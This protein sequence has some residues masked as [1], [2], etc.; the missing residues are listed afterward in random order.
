MTKIVTYDEI[1]AK[2]YINSSNCISF[3]KI[4]GKFTLYLK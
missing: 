2:I 4:K 1:V 3:T